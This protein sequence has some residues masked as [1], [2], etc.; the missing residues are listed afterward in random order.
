MIISSLIN[1]RT[2]LQ[3]K[4]IVLFVEML[5]LNELINSITMSGDIDYCS[6]IMC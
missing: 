4:Y 2:I 5:A 6:Y 3:L 1:L